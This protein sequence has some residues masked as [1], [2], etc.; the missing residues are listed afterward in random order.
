MELGGAAVVDAVALDDDARRGVVGGDMQADAVAALGQLVVGNT[1]SSA[2]TLSATV[3]SWWVASKRRWWRW[4]PT[5]S[6][7]TSMQ[8]VIVAQLAG[9]AAQLRAGLS[10]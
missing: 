2:C 10:R 1:V 4:A 7:R 5:A 3:E 8:A 6:G 9:I